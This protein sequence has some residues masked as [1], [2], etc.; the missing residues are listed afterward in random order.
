MC[1]LRK[2]HPLAPEM[3]VLPPC[4]L[5]VSQRAF[6]HTGIDAFG[7]FYVKRLRRREKWYGLMCTCLTTRIVHLF[8]MPSLSGESCMIGHDSLAG[9]GLGP[10]AY[11]C[12]NGTNF[13]YAS[14]RYKDIDG[15]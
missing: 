3:S 4:R 10:K 8:L 14:T 11:Y 1:I 5:A 6:T 13:Q 15:H 12:D 9:R 2:A 7:P